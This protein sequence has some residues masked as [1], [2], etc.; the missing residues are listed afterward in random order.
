MRRMQYAP[1]R[2]S[3]IVGPIAPLLSKTLLA[4]RADA[5]R[6]ALVTTRDEL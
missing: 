4:D 5:V 3:Q 6:R 1:Q 2:S